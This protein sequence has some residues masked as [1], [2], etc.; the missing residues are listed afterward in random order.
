MR[1]LRRSRLP[2][3]MRVK[4]QVVWTGCNDLCALFLFPFAAGRGRVQP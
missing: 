2:V 1:R 3:R 4:A